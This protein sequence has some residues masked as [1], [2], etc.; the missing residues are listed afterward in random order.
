MLFRSAHDCF[1][2]VGLHL[3]LMQSALR[4]LRSPEPELKLQRRPSD[5]TRLVKN[6][7][8]HLHARTSLHLAAPCGCCWGCGCVDVLARLAA[9][10]LLVR[11]LQKVGKH[12]PKGFRAVTHVF[13]ASNLEPVLAGHVGIYLSQTPRSH[14][15]DAAARAMPSAAV[16]LG[17]RLVN[18]HLHETSAIPQCLMVAAEAAAGMPLPPRLLI[19]DAAVLTGASCTGLRYAS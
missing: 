17:A 15:C 2:A 1:P 14:G 5:R 4:Y 8:L 13:L 7:K 11:E 6:I 18:L 12:F 3:P 16:V 9:R 19:P 10:A